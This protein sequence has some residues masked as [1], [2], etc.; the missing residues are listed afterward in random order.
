MF[1]YCSVYSYTS[2]YD[3]RTSYCYK[4]NAELAATNSFE[5]LHICKDECW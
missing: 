5:V 2:V 3:V 4:K 1:W